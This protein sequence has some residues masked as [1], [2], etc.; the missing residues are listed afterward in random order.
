MKASNCLAKLIAK[1]K[2]GWIS[3]ALIKPGMR[4][5]FAP[6]FDPGPV[7]TPNNLIASSADFAFIS[8]LS[9]IMS[10]LVGKRLWL[11]EAYHGEG[12]FI[13]GAHP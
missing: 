6:P 3:S 9:V 4:L 10:L 8:C 11:I 13:N 2:Y 12:L 1:S 5:R 7:V